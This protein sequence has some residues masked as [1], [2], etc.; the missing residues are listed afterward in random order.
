MIFDFKDK[1][2]MTTM[3]ILSFS[4]DVKLIIRNKQ[5]TFAITTKPKR[6][7]YENY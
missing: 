6:L 7:N 2:W 5:A 3:I 1:D 4:L